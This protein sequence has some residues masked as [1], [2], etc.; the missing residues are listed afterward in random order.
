MTALDTLI[1]HSAT[2]Q[3]WAVLT[4]HDI[5]DE[6]FAD[7][8]GGVANHP[9]WV[10]GHLTYAI[11]NLN[12]LLG[13]PSGRDASWAEK[14]GGGSEPV[15]DRSA[16]PSREELIET[17]QSAGETLRALV[18]E[19]GAA[20]FDEP[21]TDERLKA[22]FP[23]VGRFITHVMLVECSFHAGQLSAWRR[24]KG[25]PSVFSIE[26]NMQRLLATVAAG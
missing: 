17:Y 22:F 25:M 13:S 8:P 10:L 24:A 9:A 20:R 19:H 7:Q 23:T 26:S 5:P 1:A 12:A 16:Y 15:A 11:D 21:L 2:M 6:E 4:A 18:R 3:E 14:F